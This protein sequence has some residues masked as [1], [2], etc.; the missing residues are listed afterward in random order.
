MSPT[1]AA[2]RGATGRAGT[3]RRAVK[4]RRKPDPIRTWVRRLERTRPGLVPFVLDGLAGEYGHPVWER[5]LDPTSELV[6]TIL[7]Q[8]SADVNAEVAFEALRV[9]YPSDRP[10]EE[11]RALQGWGGA[12]L[13]TASPPDWTAVETAP[14]PELVDVIRPGGLANQKAPRIQ[15][16]LRTIREE[17]GDHS[18]EFLGDLPALEAR[19]WLTRIDGI[20]R[21]TASVLLLFCFG[22]PLMP[23]DRHV[24]RVSRRV[25]LIGPRGHGRRR[26]RD[27]PRPA[28]AGP[29][30]RGPREP[31]HPR[32][33]DLP[34]PTPRVR[35]LP[36]PVT[37]PLRRPKGTVRPASMHC[38]YS[39]HAQ[40]RSGRAR[41][42]LAADPARR[43]RPQPARGPV[44]A[45]DR[46][47]LR[48]RHGPR[49]RGGAPPA[50]DGLAGPADHRHDD[51]AHR[52]AVPRPRDQGPGRPADHRPV[53]D[54]RGR[55]QGRPPRRDRRGL[56]HQAVPLP[57]APGPDQPRPP[58]PRRS[59]PA[60][61]PRPRP[62]PRPRAAPT[63]GDRR[64]ARRSSSPRPSR[65]CST[66][67]PPT[68]ARSSRPRRSWPGAGPRPRTP[69]RPTS[70]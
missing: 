28:R 8:N 22:A 63:P 18:L 59:G 31:D 51:A 57:G 44:G 49:R 11:H 61:E 48:R 23:V 56:R 67:S 1:H 35:A 33:A 52:R 53:G 41:V 50:R 20:G 37:L 3:G 69:T 10:P 14:L 68:S 7:T 2:G 26:S 66:R 54:R 62:G 42:D 19:D 9:A 36:P 45:A 55:Q 30:V 16:T 60:A 4:R 21:K 47:R 13:S 58:P 32:A 34:R 27:L 5:R 64:R 65:A 43:R 39:G 46:R 38:L 40:P 17:R 24:E 12:G 70:G 25:G 6:L 29:D 15:A